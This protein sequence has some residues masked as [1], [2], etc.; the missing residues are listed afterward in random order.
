MVEITVSPY[1]SQP[2]TITIITDAQPDARKRF[3]FTG[4]LGNFRLRDDGSNTE[5][6][7]TFTVNP[8]VY[9]VTE[10]V[11]G[12]W[13]LTTSSAHRRRTL[14]SIWPPARLL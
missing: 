9:T 12:G 13:F 10:R 4:S 3:R 2:A 11:P 5:N 7:R 8:G 6:I 14:W 1:Q